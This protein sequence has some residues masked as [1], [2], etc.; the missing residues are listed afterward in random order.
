M[1]KN[2]LDPMAEDISQRLDAAEARVQALAQALRALADGLEQKLTEEPERDAM[3]R[4]A[5]LAHEI[6][7]AQG[8]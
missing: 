8:L 1:T 5:R 2:T 3:T 4:G 6:L 7:L